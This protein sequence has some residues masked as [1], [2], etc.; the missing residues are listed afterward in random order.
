MFPCHGNLQLSVVPNIGCC[1][2]GE[3]SAVH[4]E[5]VNRVKIVLHVVYV[6]F[7]YL[8]LTSSMAIS[9]SAYAPLYATI[10]SFIPSE[11]FWAYRIYFFSSQDVANIDKLYNLLI[12]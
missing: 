10:R 9:D 7:N 8:R 1:F 5:L 12:S 3:H 6:I 2:K 11:K 4:S